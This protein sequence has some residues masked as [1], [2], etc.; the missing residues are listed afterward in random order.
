[1]PPEEPPESND[2]LRPSA[3]V[4]SLRREI[5]QLVAQ[6]IESPCF[7][8]T[9]KCSLASRDKRSQTDF[10]KTIQGIA[11]A[12]PPNERAYVIGADQKEK[13]FF[14]IENPQEFDSANV[15]QILEK[16]LE[17]PPT[18]EAWVVE[19]DDAIKFAV[20]VLPADQPRPIVIRAQAGDDKTQ[21]LERG[22][23]WIKKD[24]GLTRAN[25]DDLEKI[26]ET[27]IEAEAE[28]RA[29]RR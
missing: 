4:E 15:R 11:N 7:E 17:P 3:R 29:E 26:Y 9:R 13:K 14:P 5:Q 6:G 27:R 10:V 25:R 12:Y 1:M 8:L 22:D 16:Y 2:Q 18:F 24:T 28:R 23:I 21:F 20:I 19:T